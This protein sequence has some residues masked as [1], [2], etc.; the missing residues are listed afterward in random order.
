LLD[1]LMGPSRDKSR[2]EPHPAVS[3]PTD[4]EPQTAAAPVT[5]GTTPAVPLL[6]LDT[7]AAALHAA[8]APS[9]VSPLAVPGASG[10]FA[11]DPKFG[12]P[13]VVSRYALRHVPSSKGGGGLFFLRS[14]KRDWT[15]IGKG[16]GFFERQGNSDKK[17]WDSDEEK[18][19]EFGRKKKKRK[20]ALKTSTERR[21]AP[22]Q[23]AESRENLGD[24]PRFEA[25]T[26]C[27]VSSSSAPPSWAVSQEAEVFPATATL[28][29]NS[30][31]AAAVAWN[32]P[33]A[34]GMLRPRGPCA[35]ALAAGGSCRPH[36]LL[37]AAAVP[38]PAASPWAPGAWQ[39]AGSWDEHPGSGNA[40][41]Q[42]ETAGWQSGC[43]STG[44]CGGVDHR[45]HIGPN[46]CGSSLLW[47]HRP[48]L[49]PHFNPATE[50][51]GGQ[52]W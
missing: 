40:A 16:G 27:S 31:V 2:E 29:A 41:W 39:S 38:Q 14:E 25:F 44:S 47:G 28:A 36:P 5:V 50:A 48:P 6:T 51:S 24:D 42:P 12:E 21:G 22:D 35:A 18:Y 20:E 49:R 45:R 23:Q 32:I 43:W 13:G 30:P 9:L 37:P 17:E 46:G 3:A 26:G 19:D 4:A 10:A 7:D 52:W 8:S 34:C 11:D 15:N 33:V 1:S